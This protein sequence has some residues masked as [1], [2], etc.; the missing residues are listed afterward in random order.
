M[1]K[2]LGLALMLASTVAS[3]T[4]LVSSNLLF[5]TH[6]KSTN[7]CDG[8]GVAC[9]Y[10]SSNCCQPYSCKYAGFSGECA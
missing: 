6:V 5:P 8:F 10:F 4:P 1:I 7:D 2:R 3:A 9:F